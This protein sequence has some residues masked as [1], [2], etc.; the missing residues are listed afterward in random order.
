MVRPFRLVLW[1][2]FFRIWLPWR[3]MYWHG[4]IFWKRHFWNTLMWRL[5]LLNSDIEG[6]LERFFLSVQIF[7]RPQTKRNFKKQFSL[8]SPKVGQKLGQ[9]VKNWPNKNQG[10][11]PI[12]IRAAE[13][14]HQFC[15]PTYC[16]NPFADNFSIQPA[17]GIHRFCHQS[18]WGNPSILS[19][20]L[21][22]KQFKKHLEEYKTEFVLEN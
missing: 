3:G 13:G 9:R 1:K 11:P 19:S 15:P 4:I 8:K 10:N 6:E 22:T 12:V 5:V 2:K 7:Y 17:E 20:D 16:G 18:Y 14:I 21:L